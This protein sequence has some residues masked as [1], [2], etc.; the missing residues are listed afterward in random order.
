MIGNES[1]VDVNTTEILPVDNRDKRCAPHISFE[2]GSCI[3]LHLLIEM[4][5]AYNK[6]NSEQIKMY[7]NYEMVN[8]AKYKKYLLKSIKSK[9]S[10]KCTT[11]KC[12]TEQTFIS[13]MKKNLKDELQKYTLRPEG[14]SGKNEWLNT[15]HINN[16]LKQYELKYPDFKFVGAVP[17]DFDS[18]PETGVPTLNYKTLQESGKTKIGIIFNLDESWKSGSHWV[19]L[20]ADIK[21]N[22]IYYFDSYGIVPEPRVR[23]LIRRIAKHCE[24]QCG[25]G[26]KNIKTDYNKIRHQYD[27]SECGVYSINFILRMLRGDS[28]EEISKSKIPDKTVNKCRTVYFNNPKI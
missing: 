16:T 13:S 10:N 18:L 5:N 4:A 6:E 12:W 28:F 21:K 26:V 19:A 9:L 22:E 3:K 7:A 8:P 2:N 23:K 24:Q 11:Q 15:S 1:P 14:P 25:G 27:N 20:Y 17:M